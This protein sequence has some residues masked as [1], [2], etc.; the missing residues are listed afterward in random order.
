M[1]CASNHLIN[2][3]SCCP[4]SRSNLSKS[5]ILILH[6]SSPKVMSILE[7][8]TTTWV[9]RIKPLGAILMP[10]L[11][12]RPQTIHQYILQALLPKCIEPYVPSKLIIPDQF[13]LLP[14]LDYWNSLLGC[15]WD[16]ILA[17]LQPMA[18]TAVSWSPNLCL[19]PLS[20][21]N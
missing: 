10:L 6:H 2:I 4:G 13:I 9:L 15:L 14:L 17:S 18:P 8:G 3:S 20:N 1:I 5:E 19:Q 11:L 7:N 12:Y 21:C 16:L